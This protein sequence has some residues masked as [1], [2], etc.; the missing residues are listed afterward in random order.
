MKL[1]PN[2]VAVLDVPIDL[3]PDEEVVLRRL[4]DVEPFGGFA[5]R[6]AKE[7]MRR[8]RMAVPRRDPVNAIAGPQT[9]MPRGLR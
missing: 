8:A 7:H 2:R 4:L 5:E 3:T 9:A 1:G 6:I